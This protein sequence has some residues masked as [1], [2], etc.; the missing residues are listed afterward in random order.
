MITSRTMLPLD[1][2]E[3]H[4]NIKRHLYIWII[5]FTTFPA[6]PRHAENQILPCDVKKD[7]LNNLCAMN[8]L[9]FYLLYQRNCY[10]NLIGLIKSSRFRDIPSASVFTVNHIDNRVRYNDNN[11][12]NSDLL[13]FPT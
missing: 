8:L 12:L 2:K 7:C 3:L 6:E 4:E 1:S 11:T 5:P 13:S 10:E 9:E